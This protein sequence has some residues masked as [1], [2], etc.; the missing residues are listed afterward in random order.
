M[1]NAQNLIVA[2]LEV[3]CLITIHHPLGIKPS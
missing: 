1:V 3:E 2:L